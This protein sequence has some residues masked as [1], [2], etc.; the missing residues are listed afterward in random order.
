MHG[1]W[2]T[3]FDSTTESPAILVD[4]LAAPCPPVAHRGSEVAGTRNPIKG[5]ATAVLLESMRPAVCLDGIEI[6]WSGVAV[7]GKTRRKKK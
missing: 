7:G 5:V 2:I 6:V 1:E 3:K 4:S